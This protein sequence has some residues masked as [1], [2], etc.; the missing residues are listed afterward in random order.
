MLRYTRT[1]VLA[2]LAAAT[3]TIS[4]CAQQ[5][6]AGSE[7][8]V[9]LAA[10][11]T[12]AATPTPTATDDAAGAEVLAPGELIRKSTR[13]MGEVVTDGK[14]WVL[15]R[16]DKDTANPPE[17]NC[18]GDCAR[19]WPPAL[20]TGTPTLQGIDRSLVGTVTR[21][22]G[23][24]QITLK[25]WP[26]YRYA[27]DLKPGQWK[28]QGVGGTWFVVAPD[29]KKNLSCLPKGTP[30]AVAPP[31]TSAPGAGGDGY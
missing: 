19:V 12:E 18:N 16:F 7:P 11:N 13:Q 15:Y 8:T 26:L 10:E 24:T 23:S 2:S 1:L 29:G 9:Q 30:K 27:G 25:G 20:T 4:G 31:T 14:G 6:V 17:S 5:P 21:A 28:G 22:D 3:V